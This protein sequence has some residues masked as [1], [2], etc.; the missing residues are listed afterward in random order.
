[1]DPGAHTE[2]L[3]DVGDEKM[4][5]ISRVADEVVGLTRD[6]RR[7]RRLQTRSGSWEERGGAPSPEGDDLSGETVETLTLSGAAHVVENVAKQ[8]SGTDDPLEVFG[9]HAAEKVA[10]Q[11]RFLKESVPVEPVESQNIASIPTLREQ[12][13]CWC[14]SCRLCGRQ[15]GVGKMSVLSYGSAPPV[16]RRY[17]VK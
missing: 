11:R 5:T 12:D 4:T 16:T 7:W 10:L 1:M 13:L 17:D 2:S 3:S 14:T 8:E 6:H 9:D 15:N